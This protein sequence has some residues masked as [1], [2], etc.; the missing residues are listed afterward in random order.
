M[1]IQWFGQSAFLLSEGETTIFIDPFDK[2]DGLTGRG[3]RWEYPP[4]EGVRADLL[5][6]THE[7]MDHNGVD[8]IEGSPRTIRSTAGIL[9]SPIGKVTAIVR[10][11]AGAWVVNGTKG[12]IS[13]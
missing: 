8:A 13:Q 10:N 12:R 7:H 2:M 1:R 11:A 3:M 5:L 6:V 4:I 9:V